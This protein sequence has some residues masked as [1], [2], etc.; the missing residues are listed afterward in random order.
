MKSNDSRK[1]FLDVPPEDVL[2]FVKANG[3]PSFRVKEIYEWF[4]KRLAR[5]FNEMTSLPAELRKALSAHYRLH[6]LSVHRKDVS[7]EDGTIRYVFSG[8]DG[9]RVSTVYLPEGERLSLCI[10]TQVGCAFRCTFCASGLVKFQRQL[11]AAEIVDQILLIHADQKRMPTNLVFM[12]MGEPL[13]NFTQVVKALRLISSPTGIGMS[14]RRVTLSTSGLVPQIMKLADEGVNVNLAVSLHA[15]RDDLRLKVMPVSGKFGV[16][17]LVKAAKYYA[18]KTNSLVTFEYILLD[19]VNDFMI[20]AVRLSYL[21]KGFENKVNLI[22]YNPVAGLPYGRP[23]HG[24][25]IRFQNWLRERG[26]PVYI[27]KPKGID[28]GSACGQ[29]GAAT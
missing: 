4:F 25:V 21:T 27:R 19:R 14:P 5:D 3:M 6:P 11:S 8:H 1:T 28:I 29:L 16:R 23:P 15:V 18:Q 22:P 20:D 26:V 9:P 24:S 7:R 10:S 2:A 13:A 12:G 17:P